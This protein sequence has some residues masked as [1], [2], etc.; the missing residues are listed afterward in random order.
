MERGQGESIVKAPAVTVVVVKY[1]GGDE[2]RG[3]L[4]SLA[5]QAFTDFETIVIDNA[6][7]AVSLSCICEQSARTPILRQDSSLGFAAGN[8][9][10]ART[11]RRR[12]LALLNPDAK[13]SPDWLAAMMRAVERRLNY[14]MDACLQI[15]MHEPWRLDGAGDYHLAYGYA[16]RGGFGHR[17]VDAPPAGECFGPC[18]AAAL[19][20]RELFLE[21][22]GCD[23]R[24]FCYHATSTLPSACAIA[25]SAASLH[26]TPLSSRPAPELQDVQA[27]SRSSMAS[28]TVSGPMCGTCPV[29][30]LLSLPLRSG[31]SFR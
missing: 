21:A 29:C 27:R 28:V 13:A 19:Y 20:P 26:R 1:N 22:G 25:A 5:R 4:A 12:W 6:S 2:L 18:R 3:C 8:N 14:R 9:V 24:Y 23:E 11:G 15:S 31:W 7:S 10:G 16:W 17:L 30:F